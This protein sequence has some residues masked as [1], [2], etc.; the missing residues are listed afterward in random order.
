MRD[1]YDGRDRVRRLLWAESGQE[2]DKYG[3]K[4]Q[5]WDEYGDQEDATTS[6]R[7]GASSEDEDNPYQAYA[8][9]PQMDWIDNLDSDDIQLMW[10]ELLS[11]RGTCNMHIPKEEVSLE[12]DDGGGVIT[13]Y[14]VDDP[15]GVV[16]ATKDYLRAKE[17]FVSE[18]LK[19]REK[20]RGGKKK[21]ATSKSEAV[22]EQKSE[23]RNEDSAAQQQSTSSKKAKSTKKGHFK[24]HSKGKEQKSSE[25]GADQ[26]EEDQESDE[27]VSEDD[28]AD[29]GDASVSSARV[30]AA[31]GEGKEAGGED[32]DEHL[33]SHEWQK[34]DPPANVGPMLRVRVQGRATS[35]IYTRQKHK[36]RDAVRQ[37]VERKVSY[38]AEGGDLGKLWQFD[39]GFFGEALPTA[40]VGRPSEDHEPDLP[41]T[42]EDE[43]TAAPLYVRFINLPPA[44]GRPGGWDEAEDLDEERKQ[45]LQQGWAILE[46]A[47]PRSESAAHSEG[48]LQPVLKPRHKP[49]KAEED[50]GPVPVP[51]DADKKAHGHV[52]SGSTG[53]QVEYC[54]LLREHL[55]EMCRRLEDDGAGSV[56]AVGE[57]KRLHD[58]RKSVELLYAYDAYSALDQDSLLQVNLGP[59]S[60]RPSTELRAP[61]PPSML[62]AQERHFSGESEAEVDKDRE[63]TTGQGRR[64]ISISMTNV[65]T[66]TTSNLA[67]ARKGPSP[68]KEGKAGYSA[69]HIDGKREFSSPGVGEDASASVL[70]MGESELDLGDVDSHARS[71]ASLN[72]SSEEIDANEASNVEKCDVFSLHSND[73]DALP[74]PGYGPVHLSSH[75]RDVDF[76]WRAAIWTNPRDA[77]GQRMTTAMWYEDRARPSFE[78]LTRR[79]NKE[80]QQV[81][82]PRKFVPVQL[83]DPFV[84]GEKRYFTSPRREDGQSEEKEG[85]TKPAEERVGSTGLAPRGKDGPIT[86][87]SVPSVAAIGSGVAPPDTSSAVSALD[88][89]TSTSLRPRNAAGAPVMVP[90]V[91]ASLQMS[92]PSSPAQAPEGSS[93]AMSMS[94]KGATIA[95][96]PGNPDLVGSRAL[97]GSKK[98]EGGQVEVLSSMILQHLESRGGY[99][100]YAQSLSKAAKGANSTSDGTDKAADKADNDDQK[101]KEPKPVAAVPH[102]SLFDHVAYTW[103]DF[104]DELRRRVEALSTQKQSLLDAYIQKNLRSAALQA[105]QG[106]NTRLE[107]RKRAVDSRGGEGMSGA[108]GPPGGAITGDTGISSCKAGDADTRSALNSAQDTFITGIALEARPESQ[109]DGAMTA[110]SASPPDGTWRC[111]AFVP[112]FSPVHFD[113]DETGMVARRTTTRGMGLTA[114]EE[115]PEAWFAD[116]VEADGLDHR[117]PRLTS[118]RE[119]V[120]KESSDRSSTLAA[121][122]AVEAKRSQRPEP[123]SFPRPRFAHRILKPPSAEGEPEPEPESEPEPEPIVAPEPIIEKYQPAKFTVSARGTLVYHQEKR[124]TTQGG[125]DITVPPTAGAF[126]TRAPR[127]LETIPSADPR[128]NTFLTSMKEDA[129]SDV[130]EPPRLDKKRD[131]NPQPTAPEIPAATSRNY[132]KHHARLVASGSRLAKQVLSKLEDP[133]GSDEDA[134]THVDEDDLAAFFREDVEEPEADRQENEEGE[135][136]LL[137][138]SAIMELFVPM[139][140]EQVGVEVGTICTTFDECS[141]AVSRRNAMLTYAGRGYAYEYLF[142]SMTDIMEA[143][144]DNI[145]EGLLK[146]IEE[147]N[148]VLHFVYKFK[149]AQREKEKGAGV[150][151]AKRPQVAPRSLSAHPGA[152]QGSEF[153]EEFS[154]NLEESSAKQEKPA[155][156]RE[157]GG[158]ARRHHSELGDEQW[159]QDFMKRVHSTVE[160]ILDIKVA[161]AA[162]ACVIY[163]VPIV[164]K[165]NDLR[166]LWLHHLQEARVFDNLIFGDLTLERLKGC[167]HDMMQ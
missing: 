50:S 81:A 55:L 11:Y 155:S 87:V 146:D 117:E 48:G 27:E 65:P 166:D 70:V 36:L 2:S 138:T 153:T 38:I 96:E 84:R 161:S 49:T 103:A 147:E 74:V 21:K 60:E 6:R 4:R 106:L 52:L 30:Q 86:S 105:Q 85:N 102:S 76:D 140:F 82:S 144:V 99:L 37:K 120:P 83:R 154:K 95:V 124:T 93:A 165:E 1:A 9:P 56:A 125:V 131:S 137:E 69:Y 75:D 63:G 19:K 23:K 34:P 59:V 39:A 127:L 41:L 132:Y 152:S 53:F 150:S 100:A 139:L 135:V 79:L 109:D 45:E 163:N 24:A 29:E 8:F 160:A 91:V 151:A 33:K 118:P 136:L 94:V 156:A 58:V 28:T 119:P 66:A 43:D 35:I 101:A 31:A 57:S 143:N 68:P 112:P 113:P 18:Y 80:Q 104:P 40:S 77:A 26:T 32:V 130:M 44:E 78:Q 149:Q 13:S 7:D 128:E 148:K 16:Q 92:P 12:I 14:R 129:V 133:E 88:K 162:K 115:P 159:S 142:L 107:E 46:P 157:S 89:D 164:P 116:T 145:S 61:V 51:E 97:V 73:G 42:D 90:A 25:A 141:A 72:S 20:R 121:R 5:F 167:M 17:L 62:E 123:K 47:P 64:S 126:G 158:K 71:R 54:R 108:T 111:P 110:R 10:S 122:L 114:R 67:T 3:Y 22:E 98:S 134:A 15:E